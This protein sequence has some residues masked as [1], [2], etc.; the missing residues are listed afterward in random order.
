MR[1]VQIRKSSK[2]KRKPLFYR[3]AAFIYRRYL[4]GNRAASVTSLE[5][6]VIALHT[7]R[8]SAAAEYQIE[9]IGQVMCAFAVLLVIFL[10]AL[11]E[12]LIRD[13]TVQ[14]NRLRRNGYG[15]TALEVDLEADV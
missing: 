12:G 4:S 13:R 10:A 7:G 9:K 15:G 6:A 8:K 11:T 5:E 3:P 2:R 14:D 1:K